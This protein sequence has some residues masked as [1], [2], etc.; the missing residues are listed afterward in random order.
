MEDKRI[1]Y[2]IKKSNLRNDLDQL[3]EE[4]KILNYFSYQNHHSIVEYKQHIV[5]TEKKIMSI[6]KSLSLLLQEEIRE[7]KN[8]IYVQYNKNKTIISDTEKL[9][10][11]NQILLDKFITEQIKYYKKILLKG[12]DVRNNG[13][14]WVIIKLIEYKASIDKFSF[15]NF[16]TLSNIDYLISIS[17]KQ[18]EINQYKLIIKGM[19]LKQQKINKIQKDTINK[20]IANKSTALHSKFKFNKNKFID[21][22]D[23]NKKKIY[24]SNNLKNIKRREHKFQTAFVTANDIDSSDNSFDSQEEVIKDEV[25][26]KSLFIDKSKVNKINKENQVKKEKIINLDNLTFYDH[27]KFINQENML[28]NLAFNDLKRKMLT[29]AN[30][31]GVFEIDVTNDIRIAQ[32]F[33]ENLKGE[34]YFKE[35]FRLQHYVEK[36]EKDL[37]K[38]KSLKIKSLKEKYDITVQ[39]NNSHKLIEL[40]LI[41]AALVGLAN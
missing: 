22:E 19:K 39:N 1:K 10:E 25:K 37:E 2:Q 20:I 28:I 12:L 29:I 35:I 4:L 16:L 14:S 8:D 38:V 11:N 24:S 17:H 27:D 34:D 41:Y 13:L 7:K 18:I 6:E 26:R 31:D 33:E 30:E 23:Q 3:K 36:L 32:Y 9:Y 15:P 5:K 21:T 40:D